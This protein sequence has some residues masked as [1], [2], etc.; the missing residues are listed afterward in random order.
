MTGL[1][2]EPTLAAVDVRVILASFVLKGPII[3]QAWHW[4]A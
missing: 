4:S 3:W 1:Q 2:A